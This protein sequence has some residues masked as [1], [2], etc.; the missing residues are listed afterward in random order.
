[1]ESKFPEKFDEIARRLKKEHGAVI[2]LSEIY[3]KRWSYIK[4]D[5]NIPPGLTAERLELDSSAGIV[6][7]CDPLQ[8][9]EAREKLKDF[10]CE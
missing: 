2:Q 8:L 10:F 3:G 6:I 7:Y 9:P 4:G 5:K 1:M